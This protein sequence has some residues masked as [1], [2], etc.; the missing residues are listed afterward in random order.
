[1]Y[2]DAAG[3]QVDQPDFRYAV[4]GIERHLSLSVEG[5]PVEPDGRIGDFDE[6][7]DVRRLRMCVRIEILSGAQ[8]GQ[9]GLRLGV[10][11]QSDRVL[12][13]E[14]GTPG[15]RLGKEIV[16]TGDHAGVWAPDRSHID[17]RSF[18]ELHPVVRAENADLS[19]LVEIPDRQ[20]MLNGVGHNLCRHPP[21]LSSLDVFSKWARMVA[22]DARWWKASSSSV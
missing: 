21:L 22:R 11:A 20:E 5:L 6:Q 14:D 17:Q 13:R 12:G 1:M 19:H 16:Q 4:S 7:E 8:H 3:V 10:L 2:F 15:Q 18:D 9:V